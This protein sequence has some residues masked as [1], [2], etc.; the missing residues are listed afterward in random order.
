MNERKGKR[1]LRGSSAWLAALILL[2]A[3]LLISLLSAV[4]IGSTDIP[5]IG[6]A[7]V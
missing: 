3:V 6:R 4:T 7:H 2:F 1:F 5:E